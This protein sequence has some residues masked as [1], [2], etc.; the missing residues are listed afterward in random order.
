MREP[1]PLF[2]GG[3][4]PRPEPD[5]P[6][7]LDPKL[8][9]TGH[10]V[11]SSA[12][13]AAVDVALLLG[14]PLLLTGEPGTGKTTLAAALAHE[15]FSDRF[16]EMQVKATTGR[17]DLLYR[18]DEMA[19][20]RDAQP[21]RTQR[22]LLEYLEFRP[23]GEAMLRACDPNTPLVHRSGRE[24]T[25]DEPLL[26]RVFGVN[27][28]RRIPVFR[29]LLPHLTAWNEPERFVVL[30]DEIDKAPRDTPNDLL[31]EFESMAFAIPEA[32]LRV[33]P[34]PGAK[35][36]IVIVTSNGEKSLPDA[37]LRRCV[38]HHITFPD[39]A[40]L[41]EI[42]AQRLGQ[43]NMDDRHLAGLM[44]LF[45]QF[46][47]DMRRRPGTAELLQWLRRA[48]SDES[49][50]AADNRLAMKEPLKRLAGIVAKQEIDIAN[51]TNAI[52][53]WASAES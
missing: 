11:P 41:D 21:N 31:E 27:R 7:P 40:E 6:G 16:L 2:T 51:A 44:Q 39:D 4:A 24:L 53:V 30:I 23:L 47:L 9:K 26:D 36:P 20:F 12:L 14:Q 34:L 32:E 3:D 42:V 43:I 19:Q 8:R 13:A 49:F 52:D 35:R 29:D 48:D 22:R 25:P 38:F 50:R 1:G 15:L 33:K 10:Y 5:L 18:F 46:R 17:E 45:K 28:E 37:F